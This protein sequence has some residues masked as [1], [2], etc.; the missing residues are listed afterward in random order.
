[1]AFDPTVKDGRYVTSTVMSDSGTETCTV[2][3]AKIPGGKRYVACD[4]RAR[5]LQRIRSTVGNEF[6]GERRA[7]DSR[8]WLQK[9]NDRPHGGLW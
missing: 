8:W 7:A 2:F 5:N 6:G 3:I 9:V 1:M 4:P